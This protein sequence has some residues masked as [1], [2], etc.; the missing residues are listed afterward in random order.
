MY[1]HAQWFDKDKG[2][3]TL[4]STRGV[5]HRRCS[6]RLAEPEQRPLGPVMPH[7]TLA[8]C[9]HPL[10]FAAGRHGR[11]PLQTVQLLLIQILPL[12]VESG[13]CA[14]QGPT[15]F[16]SSSDTSGKPVLAGKCWSSV[17][18]GIDDCL[19]CAVMN[20]TLVLARKELKYSLHDPLP[21]NLIHSERR[22]V[23]EADKVHRVR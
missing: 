13:S 16:H 2:M 8:P 9:F 4:L 7:A 21:S 1:V 11:A 14:L 5:S 15:W 19:W 3:F 22:P 17:N 12:E 6:D 18:S 23:S 20:Y 10:L